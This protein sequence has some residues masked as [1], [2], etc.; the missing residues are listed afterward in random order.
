MSAWVP[1][2]QAAS[3]LF[4]GAMITLATSDMCT[5]DPLL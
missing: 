2:A 4:S 5:G 3:L 1:F